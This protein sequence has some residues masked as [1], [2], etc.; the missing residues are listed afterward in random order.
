VDQQRR[1]LL[2]FA[3]SLLLLFAYQALLERY[4]PPPPPPGPE[5]TQPPPGPA[6]G[7]EAPAP[8]KPPLIPQERPSAPL[9]APASVEGTLVVETDL[10]RVVITPVGARLLSLELKH[11]RRTVDP[12]SEP[13]QLVQA[14]PIL[15]LTVQ[16]DGA[17]SDA[18][19]AYRS[20]RS[21]LDLRGS[22]QGALTFVAEDPS[23]VRVEKRFSFTG[24]Q[25][26][27]LL[28]VS[29]SGSGAPQ[30]VGLVTTPV[31]PENAGAAGSEVAIA[32][33]KGRLEQASPG[34]LREEPRTHDGVAWAG[35][36]VQYFLAAALPESGLARAIMTAAEALPGAPA[37]PIA[38]VDG[39]MVGGK[40]D[41][42]VFFGPKDRDVLV[43][44]GHNLDRALDFGWF[45]FVAVP[46]LHALR[47][48]QHITGNYGV[49]II[50]L[51]TLVKVATIPLTQTTFRNMREMQKLQPQILK[52]RERFKDDQVAL[53]KETME[54]YRRHH[55]N[56]LSGCIPMLLQLPIFV[57]L[58]N[59]LMYAIELRHAPFALWIDDL[60]SPD[61]LPIAGVGIPVLTLFMGATMF[62]QQWLTPQQGD[63]M[64]QRMMMF[65]PLLFTFMFIN[66]PAG[67]VL[68][69]L[70]NNVLTIAHQYYMM[71]GSS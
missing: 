51:T 9:A 50:I 39:A 14:G 59:A 53:Q 57:G 46:L 47:V 69:W 42:G 45:W 43:A 62:I 8:T 56:P 24:N 67:L 60:S 54:L 21:R 66:F 64:Q 35:F 65:M 61:R 15:P 10:M 34:E 4:Q 31:P 25:Y 2:A 5:R 41:F 32:L 63:P 44:A 55:V 22:D 13:L 40:T 52:L 20:D 18:A 16:L 26:L 58:Y 38:R 68:Y 6:P 17:R 33:A 30:S 29:V 3:L 23:G 48:L 12:N 11:Y 7:P 49:A 19:F 37:V 27:F 28:S 71:R 1:L 36:A 70:V